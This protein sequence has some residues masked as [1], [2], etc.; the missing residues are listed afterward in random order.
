VVETAP[1]TFEVQVDLRPEVGPSVSQILVVGA[2]TAADGSQ[3]ELV[4]VDVRL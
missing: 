1:G 2:G 4:V 3:P